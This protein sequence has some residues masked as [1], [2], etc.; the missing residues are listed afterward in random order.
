M[1]RNGL[2]LKKLVWRILGWAM[3]KAVGWFRGY[4]CFGILNAK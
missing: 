3:P 1:P 2:Y 4:I